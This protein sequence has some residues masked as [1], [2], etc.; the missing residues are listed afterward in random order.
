VVDKSAINVWEN[1]QNGELKLTANQLLEREHRE[2]WRS[3]Q[4]DPAPPSTDCGEA[5]F[6][7]IFRTRSRFF[8]LFLRVVAWE[9][10]DYPSGSGY[11]CYNHQQS[12]IKD[13]PF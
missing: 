9:E 10:T 8:T 12:F 4:F 5:N 7:M 3:Q 6:D 13:E 1:A 2:E 11:I